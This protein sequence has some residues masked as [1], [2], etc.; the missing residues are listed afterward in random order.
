MSPSTI[1]M[2]GMSVCLSVRPSESAYVQPFCINIMCTSHVCLIPLLYIAPFRDA[3]VLLCGWPSMEA[4]G[5]LEAFLK[6]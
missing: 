4:E 2:K 5:D 3:C 6:R 1:V